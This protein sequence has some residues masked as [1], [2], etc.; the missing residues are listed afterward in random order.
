MAP[1]ESA[2]R[3]PSSSYW[4]SM[5]FALVFPTLLTWAYFVWLAET[6][7]GIQQA[8]YAGGKCVQFVFPIV[9]VFAVLRAK[10]R[11]RWPTKK[12]MW[13]GVGFG[14]IVLAAMFL[15]YYLWLKP[16]G[17][18]QMLEQQ[19]R[20]KVE[21]L[22]LDS[23]WKYAATGLF[24]AL[25]HSLLEEYYWRWF[26]F[27]QLREKLSLTLAIAIS[28]VGFMAHHI[29]LLATFFG[30]DSPLAYVFSCAVAVGGAVWAALYASSRSLIGPWLSHMLV[31]A[32]IFLVGYDL[33]RS[34][35]N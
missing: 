1:Q 17:H 14:A 5:V 7:A 13:Y 29:I 22:G 19:V 4:T 24:Y 18:L 2:R 15:L 25:A 32:A 6:P 30:W 3:I 34:I 10:P 8:V 26:V 35:L 20:D 12:S 16:S 9:W 21:D 31:D 27:G 33:V 28:S 11:W 23:I